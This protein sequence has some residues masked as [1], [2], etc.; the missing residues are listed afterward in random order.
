MQTRDYRTPVALRG[1]W[2]NPGSVSSSIE[3]LLFR[4][5]ALTH[6]DTVLRQA[7]L[8]ELQR[9]TKFKDVVLRALGLQERS[10]DQKGACPL[11][12]VALEQGARHPW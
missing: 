2:L 8:E 4:M 1:L 6:P 7:V 12:L 3:L 11:W 9:R 5:L 10:F